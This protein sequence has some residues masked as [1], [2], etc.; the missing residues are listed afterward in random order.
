MSSENGVS[1]PGEAEMPVEQAVR[2][3][4]RVDYYK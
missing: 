1:A 4:F 3:D 2:D